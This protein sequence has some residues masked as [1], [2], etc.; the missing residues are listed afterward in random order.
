M[1]EDRMRI[2][3]LGRINLETCLQRRDRKYK[4]V[5]GR[6]GQFKPQNLGVKEWN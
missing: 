5:E 4:N 6:T 2:E 3:N 1:N